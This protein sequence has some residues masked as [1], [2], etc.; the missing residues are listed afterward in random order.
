M[1]IDFLGIQA[2]LAVAECGSFA[3]A[4]E[5]L[6][7]TQTAVSHR[8]RK[9]EESLG[10]Q[11][12]VRTSRG[13]SL[14]Q[15]G[16]ALLPRARAPLEQLEASCDA[17]RR[18]GQGAA[19]WVSFACLP[20]IAASLLV[21]LLHQVQQA[22]PAQPV[23]VFDSSPVETM[24]LLQART[25]AFGLALLQ[26][27]PAALVATAIADEPFVLTCPPGH[28]LA[29]RRSV[30]WVELQAEPLIRISLS[31]GNSMRIDRSLG[32]LRERLQWRYEVQRTAIALDM[33]RGGFGLSVVPKLA[34]GGAAGL[35]VV[36]LRGPEV[37]RP[38]ALVT[39][40]GEALDTSHRMVADAA[41]DLLRSLRLAA[42]PGR[43][44]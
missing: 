34:V 40:A 9:L 39:R 36:G 16:E 5:R 21:P 23:R 3:L 35:V 37:T 17:V 38:L 31:A 8:M 28:R 22:L 30:D 20:T 43:S 27:L 25:T 2:F 1:A 18:H 12:L 41:V 33:V 42:A 4:A 24:E 15:A 44:P 29:S 6:H 13:I 10:A 14:T 19:N 26:P 32:E 7:L 11:L